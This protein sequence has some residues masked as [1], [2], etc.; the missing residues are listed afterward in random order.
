MLAYWNADGIRGRKLELEQVLSEHGVDICLLNETHLESG[1]ALMFANYVCHW[2]DRPTLGGGTAILARRGIDY[3]AVPVS[4]LK[5]L[6]PNNM[7]LVLATTPVKL[8]AAYFSST[9]P[10]IES[11][12]TEFLS[13]G[14]PVLMTSDL[15]ANH[16]DCNSRLTRD[17]ISLLR[18]YA[19][20]NTCLIDE[21]DSQIT[22]PYTYNATPNV[23]D[24]VVEKDFVLPL[25]LTCLFCTQLG[26]PAYPDRHHMPIIPSKPTGPSRLHANALGCIPELP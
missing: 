5:H 25:H 17:R 20:R 1:R 24:I 22:A 21:P 2:T 15:K 4:G 23:P 7:H 18:N 10:L 19:D 8:V 12:Q 6:E 16:T 13:G 9:R 3:Y 11:D 14:F 26:S